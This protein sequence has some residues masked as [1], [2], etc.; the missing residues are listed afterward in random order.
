M[1]RVGDTVYQAQ[2]R[3]DTDVQARAKTLS[4]EAATALIA[5]I[6]MGVLVAAALAAAAILAARA[7]ARPLDA[8]ARVADDIAER[9]LP[10]TVAGIQ[11]GE[12]VPPEDDRGSPSSAQEITRVVTALHNVERTAV[13]LAGVMDW[14]RLTH[15]LPAVTAPRFTAQMTGSSDRSSRARAQG[16]RQQLKAADNDEARL[17]LITSTLTEVAAHVLQTSPDRINPSANLTDLGL[18]SLMAGRAESPHGADLRLRATPDGTDGSRHYQRPRPAPPPHP[19]PRP[20]LNPR[21]Q[22]PSHEVSP[23]GP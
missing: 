8:L 21:A 11:S 7:I 10:E 3:V 9:R 5:Y 1:N 12:L 20:P 17:N 6:I 19:Q 23:E 15:L 13:E 4:D 18:D 2:Q 14:E 16:L 22:G